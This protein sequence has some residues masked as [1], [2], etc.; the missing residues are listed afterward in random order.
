MKKQI[1]KGIIQTEILRDM[2]ISELRIDTETALMLVKKWFP[3]LGKDSRWCG[4]CGAS[5]VEEIYSLDCIDAVFMFEM[6]KS[7]K[8]RLRKG[9]ILNEANQVHVP[10][11]ATTDAVRHRTTKCAKLGLVAKIKG[12]NG[13][14]VKGR[15]LITSR[16][17][18]FLA[19]ESVPRRVAVWRRKIQERFT[20]TI[21]IGQAMKA[22]LETVERSKKVDRNIDVRN[23]V[24]DY[25]RED[26]F[27][28][29]RVKEGTLL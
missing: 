22:R 16:G 21:T 18:S 20:E 10:T 4:N 13:K 25:R 14:Q 15:W 23:M 24:I 29:G 19:G 5:M 6:G 26:W 28:F 1:H 7:I 11:L 3:Q 8:E 17:F 9:I 12:E 27:E 2:L